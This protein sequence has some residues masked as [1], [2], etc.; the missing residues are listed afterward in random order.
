MQTVISITATSPEGLRLVEVPAESHIS[1][2]YGADTDG[3]PGYLLSLQCSLNSSVNPSEIVCACCRLR[4]IPW[5]FT[6]GTPQGW[7]W[8]PETFI[9]PQGWTCTSFGPLPNRCLCTTSAWVQAMLPHCTK[10]MDPVRFCQQVKYCF[11]T[12]VWI[13]PVP[14]RILQTPRFSLCRQPWS[15]LKGRRISIWRKEKQKQK[16]TLVFHLILPCHTCN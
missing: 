5:S 12:P 16:T 7:D 8:L 14:V 3:F 11:Q 4:S 13:L 9:G 6:W 10:H 1:V 2:L 15:K